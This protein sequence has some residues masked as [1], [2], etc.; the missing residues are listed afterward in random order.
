MLAPLREMQERIPVHRRRAR[1][2]AA[3]R[4][5]AREGPR[6]E[7]AARRRTCA[8]GCS[9]SACERGL[10]EHGLQPPLPREPRPLTIDE[11][12]A[13][14]GARHPRRGL[15][16]SSAGGAEAG[17]VKLRGALLGAGQHRP[18]RPRPAV[19]AQRP[20]SRA[21]WRSWRWPTSRRRTCARARA[22]LPGARGLRRRRGAARARGARLLRHLHP[23]LHPPHAGRAR[24]RRAASTWCA[25]SRSRPRLDEA[26]AI[27]AAVRARGRRLP[28]LPPVPLLAAVA[29]GRSGSCPRIGPRLLRRVRGPAHG[30]QRRQR[31]TG[32]R[33]GAPIPRLAGGGILVDHGAH[34]LYQLALRARRAANGPGDRAHPAASGTTGWRTRP[35]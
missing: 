13:D 29:G 3:D 22:A 32:L 31:R 23:A 28:A 10:V 8:C 34:I 27:A 33:P 4:G 19:G 21:R 25:R 11:G 9:R 35:S 24:R 17:R 1:Q 30:G 5:R 12:T 26:E 6:D 20:A 18:A 14:D 2:G 7:G 15:R 16:A